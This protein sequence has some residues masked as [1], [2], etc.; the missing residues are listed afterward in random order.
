MDFVSSDVFEKSAA[1]NKDPIETFPWNHLEVGKIFK[2]QCLETFHS[3]RF[4]KPCHILT[5]ID[6]DGEKVNVWANDRL[7]KKLLK[8]DPKDIPYVLSLGQAV[9][10]CNRRMNAFDVHFEKSNSDYPI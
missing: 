2:V 7:A 5:L 10:G 1:L 9:I 8:K 3:A 6:S 4:G